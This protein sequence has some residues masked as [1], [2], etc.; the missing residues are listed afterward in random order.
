MVGESRP[1]AP[2]SRVKKA[3]SRQ[4]RSCK[5]CRA[6]KVKV[7]DTNRRGLGSRT[8]G[9]VPETVALFQRCLQRDAR[10][11]W[12]VQ[13]HRTTKLF[14]HG[15]LASSGNPTL[16]FDFLIL[17]SVIESNPAMLVVLMATR[18]NACMR[19]CLTKRQALSARPRKFETFA[20]RS[21]NFALG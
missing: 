4:S 1:A 21:G 14:A 16:T 6:R 7:R 15:N 2:D 8:G 18:Q 19:T 3:P 20:W 12:G 10:Y 9:T 17:S 11:R 5:V 13:H